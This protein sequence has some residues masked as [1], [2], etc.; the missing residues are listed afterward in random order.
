[1]RKAL[2]PL[3]AEFVGVF[4]LTFAGAGAI[5]ANTY[6]DGSVGLLG[7]AAAHGLALAIAVSATMSISG[8]HINPAI[9]LG[10]WSVGRIDAKNAGLYVVAQLLG[11]VAAAFAIRGLYPEMAGT[12]AALGTP[13]LASDISLVQGIVI[14]AILTFFLAFAVMGT[15]VDPA[16]PKIGGFA[17][18]LTVMF[19]ILAGGNMTGAAMNPA[20]AFG[21]ALASGSW[22]GHIAYW[23]GPILG[24]IAAMQ[25]YERLLLK[26]DG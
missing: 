21:P 1:M 25:V 16:A 6:R 19:G 2:R 23:A 7:I 14:E 4:F 9:T 15:A 12:V 13:R 3:V 10:L 22:I 26:K 24:A 18:G 8:G 17:I 5:V 20:R 11:A